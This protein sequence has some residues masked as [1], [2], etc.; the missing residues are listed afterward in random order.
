[1]VKPGDPG[2]IA[3]QA[4]QLSAY[5]SPINARQVEIE[6]YEIKG[7]G[8]QQRQRFKAVSCGFWPPNPSAAAIQP[9]RQTYRPGY[10]PG[11]SMRVT[12]TP[13]AVRPEKR[14]RSLPLTG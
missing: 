5:L 4:P 10:S 13:E 14:R 9:R 8:L 11:C 12:L 7:D 6:E 3:R 1:M 2:P